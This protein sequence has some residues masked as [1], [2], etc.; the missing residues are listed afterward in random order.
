MKQLLLNNGITMHKR[1]DNSLCCF[2][3]QENTK[4]I[5]GKNDMENDFLMFGFNM[6]DMRELNR[7]NIK[8]MHFQII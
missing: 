1:G 8:F 2:W 7:I 4:E 3:F 5:R 6:E